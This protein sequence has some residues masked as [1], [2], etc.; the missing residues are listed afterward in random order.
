[1]ADYFVLRILSGRVFY[2]IH[3]HSVTVNNDPLAVSTYISVV[4][5]CCA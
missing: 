1:M 5:P 4:I 3:H 2:T